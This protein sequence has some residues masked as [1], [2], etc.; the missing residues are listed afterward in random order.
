MYRT[1]QQFQELKT[2]ENLHANITIN[3]IGIKKVLAH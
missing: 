3:K 1:V 2:L